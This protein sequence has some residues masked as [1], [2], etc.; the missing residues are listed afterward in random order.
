MELTI[1]QQLKIIEER[2]QSHRLRYRNRGHVT[3]HDLEVEQR[4]LRRYR[5]LQAKDWRVK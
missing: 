1:E 3:E 4:L 5:E 2:L